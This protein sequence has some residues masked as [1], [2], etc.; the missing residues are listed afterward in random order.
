M[1]Y[2]KDTQDAAPLA[3]VLHQVAVCR[4]AEL[5]R[6]LEDHVKMYQ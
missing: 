5:T 4:Q 6:E 1:V 2:D 3:G